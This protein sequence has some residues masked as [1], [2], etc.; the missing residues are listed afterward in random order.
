VLPNSRVPQGNIRCMLS[1]PIRRTLNLPSVYP[2][3]EKNDTL[4]L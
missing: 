3:N 4:M 2:A 1:C